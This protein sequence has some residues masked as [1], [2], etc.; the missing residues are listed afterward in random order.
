MIEEFPFFV[1][2]AHHPGSCGGGEGLAKSFP[3]LLRKE[4]IGDCGHK[5]AEDELVLSEPLESL[6]VSGDGE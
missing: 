2:E 5:H 3:E 6:W 1:V 4:I